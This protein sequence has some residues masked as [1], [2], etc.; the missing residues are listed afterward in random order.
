MSLY[1]LLMEIMTQFQAERRFDVVGYSYM[2]K[3]S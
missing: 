1:D 3:V 2:V